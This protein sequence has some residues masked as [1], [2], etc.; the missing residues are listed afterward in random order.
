MS[1]K[2]IFFIVRTRLF[3]KRNVIL[4]IILTILFIIIYSCITLISTVKDFSDT[5]LE[6][7]PE[8]LEI[9]V[10]REDK[11]YDALANIEH[12]NFYGSFKYNQFLSQEL[13][14]LNTDKLI[15]EIEIYPLI[16]EEDILIIDGKNIITNNEMVCPKNFYPYSTDGNSKIYYNEY[17]DGASF[18][19]KTIKVTPKI[20]EEYEESKAP[21][22]FTVVGT[23]ENIRTVGNIQTCYVSKE[24]FDYL[25]TDIESI[26]YSNSNGVP[27]T[28]VAYYSDN[29]L[30]RVDKL[31]NINLVKDEL[32]KLGYN[33]TN[34]ITTNETLVN[35]ILYIP[36]FIAIIILIVVIN[37]IYSFLRKKSNYRQSNEGILKVSGYTNKDILKINTLENTFVLYLCIIISIIIYL[38]IVDIL[39]KYVLFELAYYNF[40]VAIPSFYLILTIIILTIILFIIN[41][42]ITKKSLNSSIKE[43]LEDK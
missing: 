24:A 8:Y 19:N 38:I 41:N 13:P 3:E 42:I 18:L 1:F 37:L 10:S 9:Y 35:M 17:V 40:Y 23:Y 20:H 25:Y 6:N 34:I 39:N 16:E 11:N 33:V 32:T 26:I 29:A 7:D 43:M 31:E 28:E 15:G 5:G 21:V 36:L 14:A 22:N 2:D 12:I 27:T 30:V 4:M